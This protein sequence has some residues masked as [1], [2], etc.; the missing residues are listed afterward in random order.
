MPCV[1]PGKLGLPLRQPPGLPE[2][3][4]G[5]A[6]PPRGGCA[7]SGARVGAGRAD[8]ARRHTLT[9]WHETGPELN[10]IGRLCICLHSRRLPEGIASGFP[11]GF[12]ELSHVAYV[13]R[14]M[15]QLSGA[16]GGSGRR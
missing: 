2:E 16:T 5:F 4:A 14:I 11:Q 9:G 13:C 8:R 15:R 10:A 3:M 6:A 7:F 1:L 12:I